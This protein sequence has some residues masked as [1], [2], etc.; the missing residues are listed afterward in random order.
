MTPL[1]INSM[2]PTAV[3]LRRLVSPRVLPRGLPRTLLTSSIKLI[4]AANENVPVIG[5][6][7]GLRGNLLKRINKLWLLTGC[8]LV[9][10]LG[11]GTLWY[12]RHGAAAGAN[13]NDAKLVVLGA[14][15]YA[16]RCA[17]CH[18]THLEGQANWQQHLPN[19]RLP[20][21]PHSAEGHTWHHSDRQL[22]EMTKNGPASIVPGYESDMPAFKVDL[23]DH[24]IWAALA[25]IKSTWPGDVRARQERINQQVQTKVE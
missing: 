21:P 25:Y 20:A 14:S 13:P 15:V 2:S 4:I 24:E 1:S 5:A 16:Q 3:P 18:G 12:V 9:V 11:A 10:A 6:R 7:H 22:F 23:T 17:S 8:A 19:G